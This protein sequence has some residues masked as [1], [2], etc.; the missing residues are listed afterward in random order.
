LLPI[1]EDAGI[2]IGLEKNMF[3]PEYAKP[4]HGGLTLT[5]HIP[6]MGVP[7][8]SAE[9][10]NLIDWLANQA[11]EKKKIHIGCIGGHGRTGMVLSALKYVITGDKDS[12]LYIRKHYC[13][14]AVETATQIDFLHELYGINKVPAVYSKHDLELTTYKQTIAK[15]KK[16]SST[17]L[18]EH[19][20][21]DGV[22]W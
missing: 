19:V 1:I 21:I 18:L 10:M 20:A 5:F 12:T 15:A 4:W 11:T 14:K 3:E 2:Y 13:K 8:N 16:V 9:F 7:K 17:Y 6:N 22:I